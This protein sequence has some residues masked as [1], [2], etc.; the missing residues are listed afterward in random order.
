MTDLAHLSGA[1]PHETSYSEPDKPNSNHVWPASDSIDSPSGY[2]LEIDDADSS[3]EVWIGKYP[4]IWTFV[5][6]ASGLICGIF[7]IHL[8]SHPEWINE[9]LMILIRANIPDVGKTVK[10]DGIGLGNRQKTYTAR[11]DNLSILQS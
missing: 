11:K 10:V 8:G 7:Y 4:S 3:A 5:H 1:S 9:P 2:F 6:Q